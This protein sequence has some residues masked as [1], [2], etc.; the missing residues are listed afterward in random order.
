MLFVGWACCVPMQEELKTVS[1]LKKALYA[2]C[3]E[4]NIPNHDHGFQTF[5]PNS[6]KQF[7]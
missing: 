3:I 4:F 1:N 6:Q 7:N 5:N 2:I